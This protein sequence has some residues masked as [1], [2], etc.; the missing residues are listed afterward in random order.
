MLLQYP[1][2]L[3][4]LYILGPQLHRSGPKKFVYHTQC[5]LSDAIPSPIQQVNELDHKGDYCLVSE[6][7]QHGLRPATHVLFN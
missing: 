5:F 1:I 7:C 3:G 2:D 4:A 6:E